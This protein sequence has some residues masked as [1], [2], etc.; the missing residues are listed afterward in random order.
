[1]IRFA[2]LGIAMGNATTEVKSAAR[3][4]TGDCGKGGVAGAL[5]KF[6]L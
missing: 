5:K 1:M 6:V 3:E 2:G 4:V